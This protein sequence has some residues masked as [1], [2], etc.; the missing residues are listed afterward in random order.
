MS[1]RSVPNTY[2]NCQSV[3]NMMPNLTL[4][5]NSINQINEYEEKESGN[6]HISIN[7]HKKNICRTPITQ[8]TQFCEKN[9]LVNVGIRH[10]LRHWW[11]CQA[12][13]WQALVGVSDIY[14]FWLGFLGKIP[15]SKYSFNSRKRISRRWCF[16]FNLVS[17]K[18]YYLK[19]FKAKTLLRRMLNLTCH[20]LALPFPNYN[21]TSIVRKCRNQI[22]ENMN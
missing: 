3:K 7:D 19:L 15:L 22:F 4:Q 5:I 9:A 21:S 13:P 18:K 12:F 17:T 10:L 14:L 2:K 20:S 11:V 6:G 16:Q 1:T 8:K